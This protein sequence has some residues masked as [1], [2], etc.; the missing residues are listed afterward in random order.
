MS[1]EKKLDLTREVARQVSE[2]LADKAL[3]TANAFREANPAADKVAILAVTATGMVLQWSDDIEDGPMRTTSTS[4]LASKF[5]TEAMAEV[6]Q[7]LQAEVDS[8]AFPAAVAMMDIV[9]KVTT[10]NR[11]EQEHDDE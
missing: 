2:A 5:V 3:V 8:G 6:G 9:R 10:L 1:P 11:E 7:I 4:I